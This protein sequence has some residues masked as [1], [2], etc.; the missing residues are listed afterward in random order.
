MR[1]WDISPGNLC[2]KHLLGEHAELHAVW[3]ILTQGKK[4]FSRHP[5]TLRWKGKLKA[6]YLRHSLLVEEMERRGFN[7][8]SFLHQKLAT[9]KE[10][11]DVFVDL[12]K[13]QIEL[14]REKNCNCEI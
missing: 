2:R 14:L 4:G 5:E 6:L 11:Q 7:H 9:G 1:I 12:P 3:S 13:R 8:Q 10:T